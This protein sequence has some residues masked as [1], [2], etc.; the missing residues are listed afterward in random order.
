MNARYL[1]SLLTIVLLLSSCW[2]SKNLEVES[3][4]G[5]KLAFIELGSGSPAIVME[6][7]FDAG[8]ESWGWLPD[9]LAKH[10]KVYAYNRPGYGKSNQQ[11]IPES[12]EEIA[13]YLH[14]NLKARNIP[15]PYVLVG[16][17][18]GALMVNMFTRLYP[19]EVHGVLMIEPTHP[20]FYDYIKENEELIYNILVDKIGESQRFYEIDLVKNC[21][22]E[23]Q[24]VPEFPDVPLT[25]L[26]AG[27]HTSIESDALRS[28]MLEFH[29]DLKD[30]STKGKRYIVKR[31]GHHIHK[32]EPELVESEILKLLNS[33]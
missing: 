17:R 27:K 3:R 6:S 5:N 11:E 1:I 9:S 25:I 14:S 22:E 30:M 13:Q 12:I 4:W 32:H 16:Y 7:G 8:L 33:P 31:S 24:N 10:S 20:D 23:F 28:K 18:E 2:S 26:M 21:S 19:D 15:P 29:K